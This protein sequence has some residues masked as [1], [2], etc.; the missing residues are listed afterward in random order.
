MRVNYACSSILK[1][2]T[3]DEKAVVPP[4]YH[5]DSKKV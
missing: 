4:Q 1:S 5:P 2:M 3:E